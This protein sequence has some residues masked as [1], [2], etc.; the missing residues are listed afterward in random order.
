MRSLGLI[1]ALVLTF[2]AT[3]SRVAAQA[4]V[5]QYRGDYGLES[6]TQQPQGSYFGM[7]FNHYHAPIARDGDGTTEL[8]FTTINSLALTGEYSSRYTIFGGRYAA[9]LMVPWMTSSFGLPQSQ[10]DPVGKWGFSDVY[11][12]P[13]QLG[14]TFEQA[15]VVFGQGVYMPTGRFTEGQRHN[16]G[17]G[18]W[19]WE[20][21]LGTTYYADSARGQSISGLFSYQ[22][23]SNVK[24]TDKR[25]GQ[26][27]TL[28]GGIGTKVPHINAKAGLVYY[29]RWKL[30][31]DQN[32]VLPPDFRHRDE[33]YAFGPEVTARWVASAATAIFTLRYFIESNNRS[34]PEGNSLFLIANIYRPNVKPIQQ[35][36]ARR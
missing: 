15:D 2:A 17:L 35:L 36:V 29:A 31:P 27:L 13:I 24:G 26:T 6:G 1:A 23:Q 34:A 22:V 3:P 5:P 9:L 19:S 10:Q 21:T 25:P 4:A 30:T 12:S 16:T 32:Y 28:E 14:W 33:Y 20:T 7:L 8:L 11:V 18:L